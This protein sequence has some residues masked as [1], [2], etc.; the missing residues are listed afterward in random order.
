M[1]PKPTFFLLNY[2][3]T[4]KGKDLY[5]QPFLSC[6]ETLGPAPSLSLGDLDRQRA[7]AWSQVPGLGILNPVAP[8]STPLREKGHCWQCRLP[9]T[10]QGRAAVFCEGEIMSLLINWGGSRD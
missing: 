5:Q 4:S 8:Q 7:S 10:A 2:Q 6:G 9:H 1:A 3:V